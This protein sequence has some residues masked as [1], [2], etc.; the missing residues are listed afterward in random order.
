MLPRHTLRITVVLVAALSLARPASAASSKGGCPEGETKYRDKCVRACATDG[1]FAQ[2]D[3]CEC[4]V[5]FG[6]LLLGN[7]N[8]QCDRLRCQTGAVFDAKRPCDCPA[9]FEK[10]TARKGKV[11]CELK[12]HAKAK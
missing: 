6:K 2:P 1:E 8:G 9:G 4:P 11:R 7:G 12:K 5:G 3:A 10:S